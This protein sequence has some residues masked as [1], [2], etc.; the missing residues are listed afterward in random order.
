MMGYINQVVWLKWLMSF[1]EGQINWKYP[2][3]NPGCSNIWLDLKY[4]LGQTPDY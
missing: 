2:N 1:S 4:L 3:L